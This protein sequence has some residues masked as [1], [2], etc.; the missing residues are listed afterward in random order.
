MDEGQVNLMLYDRCQKGYSRLNKNAEML[1]QI[2]P[3]TYRLQKINRPKEFNGEINAE[4]ILL[5][6]IRGPEVIMVTA[7]GTEADYVLE[8]AKFYCDEHK[9]PYSNIVII[10][11]DVNSQLFKDKGYTVMPATAGNSHF[12]P[13]EARG[14]VEKIQSLM[15]TSSMDN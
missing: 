14:L 7:A 13:G 4:D 5:S 8:S 2:L 12:H 11:H 6:D 9:I 15:P 1:G 10:V 3:D